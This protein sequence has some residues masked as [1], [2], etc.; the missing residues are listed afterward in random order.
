MYQYAPHA[1]PQKYI[2]YSIICYLIRFLKN[3]PSHIFHRNKRL[4]C[5]VWRRHIYDVLNS[6]SIAN[7]HTAWFPF[8]MCCVLLEGGLVVECDIKRGF[9]KMADN[10]VPLVQRNKLFNA[11]VTH[12][13][14]FFNG[15]CRTDS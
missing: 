3:N 2:A 13:K 7:K 9:W 8:A 11:N 10:V 12:Y 14:K 15:H 1:I 6:R 5:L 4:R